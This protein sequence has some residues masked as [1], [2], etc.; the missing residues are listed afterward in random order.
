MDPVVIVFIV[1]AV[2]G[3]VALAV[4]AVRMEAG[5]RRFRR[6]HLGS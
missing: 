2:M 3:P 6:E 1:S 4:Y 5:W